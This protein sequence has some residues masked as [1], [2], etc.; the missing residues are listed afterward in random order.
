MELAG[1]ARRVLLGPDRPR[2]PARP[3]PPSRFR[4]Y[5]APLGLLALIGLGLANGTYLMDNRDQSGPVAVLLSAWAVLPV[6]IALRRPLLAWRVA[7]PLT[8][9]G[10]L[11]AGPREPWPWPPVQIFAFL[12]VLG[13]LAF[14]EE[15]AVIAWVT[16]LN[17]V[18]VFLF[19]PWANAWGVAVLFV[20]IALAGEMVSRRRGSRAELARQAELTELEQA[21]RAV[22]EERTRI[23][24]E[25][26]D[27]VAH[28]MSMIAVRAET[29]PYRLTGLPAPVQAEFGTIAAAARE[30]LT[31]MRRLLG[32]LRAETDESPRAP[33]PGLADLTE[34]IGTARR[35][36]VAVELTTVEGAEVP[37]GVGLAA[38]RIVQEAL[39][40]AARH[41]PGG[42]VRVAVRG[43]PEA[44]EVEIENDPG[45]SGSDPV[46]APPAISPS[47]SGPGHGLVGMRERAGLLGGTLEAGP[48]PDGGYRV[49]A[50]LPLRE[51][52]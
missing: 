45:A 28:H 2:P 49:G 33:Q 30:A 27:V 10:V 48:R 43:G 18:P 19:S 7:Y 47:G 13:L 24:R 46:A 15:S 37:E 39:A 29:A 16:A 23:A 8:F 6:L 9:L 38:Y 44:L 36:G 35:A 25:M 17:V 51:G 34:L 41:A 1:P 50:R 52:R 31:D 26:H 32:V 3:S 21:R 20:A 22:L 12:A 14:R 40:N 4:G 11:G 42:R 5:A